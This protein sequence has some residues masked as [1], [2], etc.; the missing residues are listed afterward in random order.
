MILRAALMVTTACLTS[1]S[2]AADAL[3]KNPPQ[4]QM[5]WSLYRSQSAVKENLFLSPSSLYVALSLT[6]EG[7]QGDV[8]KEAIRFLGLPAQEGALHP[9][10]VDHLKQLEQDQN[11]Q[12]VMGNS[13]WT[14]RKEDGVKP[15]SKDYEKSA[16]EIYGA[17]VKSVNF[18]P[19]KKTVDQ[20][21]LWVRQK[22]RGKIKEIVTVSDLNMQTAV[23]LNAIY[24]KGSWDSKFDKTNTSSGKFF[25][26]GG[27]LVRPFMDQT[28]NYEYLENEQAQIVNLPY[29]GAQLAM[30][31]IL[32][33]EGKSLENLEESLNPEKL[34][35]WFQSMKS[36]R[37]HLRL[38][39]FEIKWG[40]KD[41]KDDLIKIGM[42]ASGD[43][44]PLGSEQMAI[45]GV[46]HKTLIKVD[47][48]G[49]EAAAVTAVV[50]RS[51]QL[52]PEPKQFIVNR[53]FFFVI[54]DLS[55]NNWHFIGRV[56][57]P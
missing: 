50:G 18:V 43:F 35:S 14:D 37:T 15:P 47:E 55:H 27:E 30:T 36:E 53:P 1:P 11:V 38:P 54:R 6:F 34:N 39:K 16:R 5:G 42:P 46:L 8:R 56:L 31:I 23:V 48:E 7:S 10:L 19:A 22:T 29:K 21:N 9:P 52:K 24:F 20:I 57:K 26:A 28:R 12:M 33:K 41:L 4:N 3:A 51:L 49:S 17:T 2:S 40:V 44:S 45:S 25:S 13:V 32:P